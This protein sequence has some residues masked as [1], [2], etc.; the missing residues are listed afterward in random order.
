MCNYFQISV[1]LSR[2]RVLLFILSKIMSSR[3]SSWR[4]YPNQ[5]YI[6][7]RFRGL[8]TI[9]IIKKA[10]YLYTNILFF[11][12]K[13][14]HKF[15]F[16]YTIYPFPVLFCVLLIPDPYPSI[17][18]FGWQNLYSWRC[19]IWYFH[20]HYQWHMWIITLSHYIRQSVCAIF[21]VHSILYG[22][23]HIL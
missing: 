1:P 16:N 17:L 7:E 12:R 5:K 6:C 18:T 22:V 19:C 15:H 13:L 4:I 10:F 8:G 23:W 21:C 20:H 11:S 3:H 2:I 9:L 14:V